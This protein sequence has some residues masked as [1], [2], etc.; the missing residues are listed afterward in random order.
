[1]AYDEMIRMTDTPQS[2]WWIVLSDDKKRARINCISHLLSVIP[3]NKVRFRKPVLGKRN[4][5]P[6]DHVPDQGT[7]NVVPDVS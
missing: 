4:K 7:R 3:Y 6:K 1:V 5:R 2:P